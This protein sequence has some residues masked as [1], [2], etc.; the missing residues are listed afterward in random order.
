MTKSAFFK[1]HFF[2]SR[3]RPRQTKDFSFVKFLEDKYIV[4]LC[5]FVYLEKVKARLRHHDASRQHV[6]PPVIVVVTWPVKLTP[7]PPRQQGHVAGLTGGE[8]DVTEHVEG[9]QD[10]SVVVQVDTSVLCV[11][12]IEG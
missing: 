1:G 6:G 10:H 2:S 3:F 5:A 12:Q 4:F 9:L 11:R 8:C 7:G